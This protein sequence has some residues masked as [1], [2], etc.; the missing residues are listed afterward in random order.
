MH[1]LT[2]VSTW[3]STYAV[4]KCTVL[5]AQ[6]QKPMIRQ[7]GKSSTHHM[8]VLFSTESCAVTSEQTANRQCRHTN[9]AYSLGAEA[10]SLAAPQ[11][12]TR[13][14]YHVL[15]AFKQTDERHSQIGALHET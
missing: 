6:R 14:K 1:H 4:W 3:L 12:S 2:S 10:W 9:L 7:D 5:E 15:P 8:I 13:Y 11:M